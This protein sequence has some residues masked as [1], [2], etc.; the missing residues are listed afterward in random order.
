MKFS[1]IL[2]VF[3]RAH[4]IGSAL[5]SVLDQTRPADEVIVVDDG[6]TDDLMVTLEPFMDKITLLRQ[7]N[8]GAAGARNAGC[9]VATGDWLTFQDSDDIWSPDHLAVAERDLAVSAPDIVAH[10]GDVTFVGPGY[11]QGL[12]ALKRIQFPED[13][14]IRIE[15]PLPLVLSGMSLSGSAIRRNTFEKL[16]GL[17][18]SMR[19]YEDSAFFCQLALEGPF[20][21]TGRSVI[22]AQRL[23]ESTL[24]LSGLGRTEAIYA[25]QMQ[26]RVFEAL[27]T[28][29]LLTWQRLLVNRKLSGAEFSLAQVI[30]LTDPAKARAILRQSAQRHPSPLIGWSK[31]IASFARM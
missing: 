10:L 18:A 12:F 24:A 6:S 23:E 30:A 17:D 8:A 28:K 26:G 7:A 4:S 19:I 14:A 27:L 22:F 25:L 21:V 15:E 31:A 13:V 5:Q 11:R 3:N 2:P 20:V 29:D 16:G 1:V 9:A